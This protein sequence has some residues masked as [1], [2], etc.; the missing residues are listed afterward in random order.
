LFVTVH[1]AE[2]LKNTEL[3][4]KMDPYVQVKIGGETQTTRVHKKGG[5]TPT[6]E[7]QFLFNLTGVPA[8]ENTL[9]IVVYNKE[10]L[11][12][13]YVGRGDVVV[14]QLLAKGGQA[15][16][17]QLVD[18]SNFRKMCGKLLLTCK[19]YFLFY[20]FS[21]CAA[22]CSPVSVALSFICSLCV[23]QAAHV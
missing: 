13:D 3:F 9:H 11:S 19:C 23:R 18:P 7:Q 21:V 20:V 12:D 2:N 6:W 10:T 4:G 5:K 14:E 17:Y 22:S 15:A 8:K 1:K 16:W